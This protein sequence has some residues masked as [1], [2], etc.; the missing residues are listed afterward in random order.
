MTIKPKGSKV[1]IRKVEL[2]NATKSGII[3]GS[4]KPAEGEL[5]TG[6]IVAYGPGGWVYNADGT[7]NRTEM[8]VSTGDVILYYPRSG[9]PVR[10]GSEYLLLMDVS[11]ILAKVEMD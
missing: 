7:G 8:D 3:L 9:A 10:S 11:E 5:L 6:E 4:G 2:T 1:L